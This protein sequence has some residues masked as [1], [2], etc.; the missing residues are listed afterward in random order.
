MIYSSLWGGDLQA[1]ILQGA[2]RGLFQQQP[3]G[4]SAPPTTCCPSLGDKMPNGT[5]LGARGAY[6]LMSPKTPLND[7]FFDGY[8]QARGVWPV[9]AAYR[10]TQ[11]L[12]GPEVGD[13]EG[14][15]GERRQEAEP[16]GDRGGAA[17][18]PSGSRPAG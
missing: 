3:A 17:R 8:S 12:L 5:I 13:R 15:G 10:I 11:A 14:D 7:W 4:A 18:T 6:G 16:G 1:F 2:P 9:Q